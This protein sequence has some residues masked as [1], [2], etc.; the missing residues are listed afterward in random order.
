MKNGENTRQ[1]LEVGVEELVRDRPGWHIGPNACARR[2]E[3]DSSQSN[4]ALP[5]RFALLDAVAQSSVLGLAF[6][7]ASK[8]T[9]AQACVVHPTALVC[10]PMP[11]WRMSLW[12]LSNLMSIIAA[13]LLV[14]T[15]IVMMS[16]VGSR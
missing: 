16:R 8:D 6:A 15:R 2:I 14:K 11:R 12:H 10:K 1:G 3:V 13:L 7:E 9:S 5:K 4:D